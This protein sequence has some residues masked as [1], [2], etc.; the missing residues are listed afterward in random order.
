MGHT[1]VVE[2]TPTDPRP[3]VPESET[4]LQWQARCSECD[5]VG[6]VRQ[7]SEHEAHEDASAHESST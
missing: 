5:W 6:P 4:E 3:F 2:S 1:I 7:H